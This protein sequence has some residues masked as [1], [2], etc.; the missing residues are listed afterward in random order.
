M[1]EEY[2]Q[3]LEQQIRQSW[4]LAHDPNLMLCV[5]PADEVAKDNGEKMLRL[6]RSAM[7][8]PG[9]SLVV[10][11]PE[12]VVF[13]FAKRQSAAETAVKPGAAPMRVQLNSVAAV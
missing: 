4:D 3:Y 12:C 2:V 8:R 1:T 5:V 9:E 6:I 13:G 7:E 10:A 11:T